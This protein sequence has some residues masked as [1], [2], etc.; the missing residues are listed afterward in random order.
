MSIKIGDVDLFDSAVNTEFRVAILERVIDRLLRAAPPGT[1]SPQDM[2]KIRAEVLAE[3][4]K[5]Y[6]SAGLGWKAK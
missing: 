4:Q 2:E 5:K 1:L 6:P 3:M